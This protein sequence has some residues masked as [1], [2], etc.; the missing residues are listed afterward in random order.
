MRQDVFL[1]QLKM[2]SQNFSQR[3]F[4]NERIEQ[5]KRLIEKHEVTETNFVNACHWFI[6]NDK[7]PS[8]NLFEQRFLSEKTRKEFEVFE[9]YKPCSRCNDEGF[10][11]VK[12]EKEK[13]LIMKCHLC[14]KGEYHFKNWGLQTYTPNFLLIDDP[15]V[16]YL[17]TLGDKMP[18]FDS[19]VK[20]MAKVFKESEEYFKQGKI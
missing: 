13:K 12:D 8:I 11:W 3:Y 10:V 14:D 9:I 15:V 4:T 1:S 6:R 2:L 20:R 17:K 5:I 19:L 18:K 16:T 7:Q